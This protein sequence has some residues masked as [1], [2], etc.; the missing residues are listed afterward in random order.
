MQKQDQSLCGACVKT[1][2]DN[3]NRKSD[4][5]RLLFLA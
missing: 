5:A 4:K 3:Q 1:E 2:R